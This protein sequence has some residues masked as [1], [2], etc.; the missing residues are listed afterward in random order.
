VRAHPDGIAGLQTFGRNAMHRYNNMDH[1]MLAGLLAARNVL[2]ERHD[3]W[4]VNADERWVE[5]GR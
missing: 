2:G 3:L 5:D 1:A 4:E